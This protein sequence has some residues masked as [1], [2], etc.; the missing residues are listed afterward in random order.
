MAIIGEKIIREN[1]GEVFNESN[2]AIVFHGENFDS[3]LHT[4][5]F[6]NSQGLPTYETKE[7]GLTV[8]KFERENPDVSIVTTAIEQA[9]YMK[10]V[11][12]AISIMLSDFRSRMRHI[13]HSMMS[14]DR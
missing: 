13:T 9:E 5:V 2:G 7:V 4:R 12:K 8:T 6:I 11:S 14:S 1:I 10:V 3:K